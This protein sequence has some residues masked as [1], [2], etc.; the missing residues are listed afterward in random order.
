V[1]RRHHDGQTVFG[2]KFRVTGKLNTL[3]R[4]TPVDP[5]GPTGKQVLFTN[6]DQNLGRAC[7]GLSDPVYHESGLPP[8]TTAGRARRS[9]AVTVTV[10][11]GLGPE[12]RVPDRRVG[13]STGTPN[14]LRTV[15]T[16]LFFPKTRTSSS[17]S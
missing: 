10:A 16:C 2:L 13:P 5:K 1:V 6:S 3:A 14:C 4:V 15:L 8:G 12:S 11:S 17:S 7:R 9:L